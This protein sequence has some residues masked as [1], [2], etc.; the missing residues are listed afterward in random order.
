[1]IF[2]IVGSKLVLQLYVTIIMFEF[3]EIRN[4]SEKQTNDYEI[5]DHIKYKTKRRLGLLEP[6]DFSPVSI[7]DTQKDFRLFHSAVAKVNL[8]HHRA[9]RMLQTQ[10]QYQN[11]AVINYTLKYDPV[12]PIENT[13]QKRFQKWRLNDMEK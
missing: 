8:L 9:T 5:I 10:G 7:A 13:G 3:E 1:M 12:G 6:K 4:D 2:M 11:Q